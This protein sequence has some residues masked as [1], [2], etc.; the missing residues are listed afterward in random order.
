M[1]SVVR[2]LTCLHQAQ[3]S[4]GGRVLQVLHDGGVR[5]PALDPGLQGFEVVRD[6]V[7]G[8]AGSFVGRCP[9][10]GQPLVSDTAAATIVEPWS[11][12]QPDGVYS[13]GMDGTTGPAGP[14]EPDAALAVV[15]KALTPTMA[16]QIF[17]VRLIF[18]AVL[19][20]LVAV[21]A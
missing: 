12:T 9:A 3:W 1:S 2:C 4:A 15:R 17:D 6:C 11:V 10:C 13:I 19:L 8:D 20:F 5:R 21:V 14:M 16:E 7:R 18:V